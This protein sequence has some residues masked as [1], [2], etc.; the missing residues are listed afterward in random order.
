MKFYFVILLC[1]G[2]AC[3]GDEPVP[4]VSLQDL[5]LST[6]PT[7]SS[8]S[9]GYYNDSKVE[10]PFVLRLLNDAGAEVE[11]INYYDAG[12]GIYMRG[13]EDGKYFVIAETNL[14]E[15]ILPLIKK[16]E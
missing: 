4:E 9:I 10:F 12:E 16:S 6:N 2:L 8:T 11:R 5:Y 13:K 7:A 14:G 1:L 15:I 3:C